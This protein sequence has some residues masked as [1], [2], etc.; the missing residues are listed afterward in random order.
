MEEGEIDCAQSLYNQDKKIL[1]LRAYTVYE[2]VI[3][4]IVQ[5]FGVAILM[6]CILN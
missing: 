1:C 5:I 6:Q 2:T 3:A 4:N